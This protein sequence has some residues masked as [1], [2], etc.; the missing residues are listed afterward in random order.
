MWKICYWKM[1]AWWQLCLHKRILC[2]RSTTPFWFFVFFFYLKRF[3]K[4]RVRYRIYFEL[5]RKLVQYVLVYYQLT[6]KCIRA[7][8]DN[9]QA[10][11]VLY[12]I[13]QSSPI[14]DRSAIW[15]LSSVAWNPV[16]FLKKGLRREAFLWPRL[17]TD[18]LLQ[19]HLHYSIFFTSC[20]KCSGLN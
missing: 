10:C 17:L 2:S 12:I 4:G 19:D 3:S 5:L 15:M 9:M 1:P 11:I 13:Y 20:N 16:G 14:T 18:F 8:A 7:F 6:M